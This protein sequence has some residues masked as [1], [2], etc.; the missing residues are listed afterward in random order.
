[1]SIPLK[2]LSVAALVLAPALPASAAEQFAPPTGCEGYLTVQL[3]SCQVANYYRCQQDNPG[4]QWTTY[5]DSEGPFY[6]SMI[7]AETR[8]VRSFDH[9]DG[10][11]EFLDEES[12][13]HASF[14]A[15][16]DTGRDDYDF[17]TTTDYGETRHFKGFD[18][19]TGGTV[20]ID[21][22]TLER[23]TFQMTASNAEGEFLH[24]REGNQLIS[25]EWRVFFADT[26]HFENAF[27]DKVDS[28]DTPVEFVFPGDKGFFSTKP[29]YGCDMMM[30]GGA[31]AVVPAGYR[32]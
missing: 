9:F 22:V 17:S 1:M 20:K 3:K 24:S 6:T 28:V 15:L 13:D 4:D 26:E 12:P 10:S 19:L 18:E 31:T 8:W 29:Q 25:R 23:T 14:S 7:D 27:G 21:G 5:F 16:L 30:T 11:W 32:D 2:S